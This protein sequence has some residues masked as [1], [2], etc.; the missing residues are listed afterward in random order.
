MNADSIRPAVKVCGCGR[1]YD[2]ESWFDLQEVGRQ[3]F[4]EDG[5]NRID[6]RNCACGST[7]GVVMVGGA[8]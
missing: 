3:D 1:V 2:K 7:I 4:E 8:P 5:D 6:V